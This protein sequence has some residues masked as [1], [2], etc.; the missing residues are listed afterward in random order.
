MTRHRLLILSFSELRRDPRVLRQ[1]EIFAERYEVITCG[2]GPAPAGVADHIEVPAR[3]ARWRRS[4]VALGALLAAR[5]HHRL[6]FGS[7]RIALVLR[8]VRRRPPV[9]LV[10]ANDVLAVPAAVELAPRAGVHADLHEYSPQ[11]GDGVVWK[12]T[13]AP[14]MRWAVRKYVTRAA[15]VTTVAHGI[16]EEYKKKFGVDADVVPNATRYRDDLETTPTATPIRLVHTGAAGRGRRIEVMIDAVAQV[17]ARTPGRFEL[18]LY[19][20]AGDERYI[21]ELAERAG[22]EAVTGIRVREPVG[23]TELVPMMNTYDVGIHVLPP[24]SFNNHWALPNKVFEYVQARL[25]LVIGPSPEMARLVRAHGLGA[26]ADGFGVEDVAATLGA[27]TPGA[28]DAYKSAAH[29][30]AEE[31]D[32]GRLSEPWVDA[33]EALLDS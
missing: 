8:E 11:Q 10:I 5:R 25:A 16:A 32:A 9:D 29:R 22:D 4:T 33:V 17:N 14:L 13:I 28:V 3:L 23:F 18:D 27:L 20:V 19:L 2:F 6:Y 26:I 7:E 31:L 24:V 21:R 30:A 15:S 12:A 1:V